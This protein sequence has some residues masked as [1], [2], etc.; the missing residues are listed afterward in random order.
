MGN[1]LFP[2]AVCLVLMAA[3]LIGGGVGG[4]VFAWVVW[5]LL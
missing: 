3:A 5:H 4:F 1:H 2:A